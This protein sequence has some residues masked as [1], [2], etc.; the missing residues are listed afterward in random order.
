MAGFRVTMHKAPGIS[1]N[2]RRTRLHRAYSILLDSARKA[3]DRRAAEKAERE[4]SDA[5]DH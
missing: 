2:E 3:R 1:G 5:D 4:G